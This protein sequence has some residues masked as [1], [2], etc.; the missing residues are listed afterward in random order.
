M[1]KSDAPPAE[2]EENNEQEPDISPK[3]NASTVTDEENK[4]ENINLKSAE[5]ITS[6][7]SEDEG[8][9]EDLSK[10]SIQT[11]A[12]CSEMRYKAIA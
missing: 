3:S 11:T 2:E 9:R 8:D 10:K 5:E 6:P 7:E 1:S 12:L 4:Q